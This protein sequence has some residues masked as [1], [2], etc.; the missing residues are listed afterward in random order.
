MKFGYA[1]VST[2]EQNLDL[3][4]DALTAA[5]AERIFEDHGISG[6]AVIK[7]SFL[8]MMALTRPGDEIIVWRL[9]RLSRRLIDLITELQ[10]FEDAG[11]SFRSVKENIETTSPAG[12]LFFHMIGAF[13]EFEREVALERTEAGL[14]AARRSGKKFGRPSQIKD[15]QW[16]I[17]KTLMQGPTPMNGAQI[18]RMLG[19]SKQAVH[20]RI[21]NEREALEA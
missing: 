17:A 13:A 5:G 15:E 19:I 7:P 21:K 8:E 3:Q 2:E 4:I 10:K 20:R 16:D 6:A 9:D 12:R 14:A 1:R 11:V 18:A